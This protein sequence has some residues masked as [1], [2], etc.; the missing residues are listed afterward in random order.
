LRDDLDQLTQAVCPA[1]RQT[2]GVGVDNSATLLTAAGDNP[3]HLRS[4]A[5]FAALGG[6]NPLPPSSGKTN[7]IA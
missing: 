5:G 6:V 1:L 7:R 4:D 3:E 2:S